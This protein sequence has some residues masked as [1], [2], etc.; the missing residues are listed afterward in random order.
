MNTALRWTLR[1]S[2]VYD[3][4]AFVLLMAMPQWLFDLFAHPR[5]DDP[6]LFRLAGL[7][8]LMAPPVYWLAS[9]TLEQSLVTASVLLRVVG[10]IGIAAIVLWHAPAGAAAYW[11]FVVGDFVWAALIVAVWRSNSSS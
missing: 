4:V 2:V 8:L 11:S 7:P 3:L 5:P 1:A 10:G 9:I 6:F